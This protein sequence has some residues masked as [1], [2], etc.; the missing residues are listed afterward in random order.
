M[1]QSN[2]DYLVSEGKFEA[3]SVAYELK[4]SLK[5][6]PQPTWFVLMFPGYLTFDDLHQAIMCC[7][8]WMDCHLYDF[9]LPD[10]KATIKLL[11]EEDADFSDIIGLPQNNYFDSLS[12]TI[13]ELLNGCKK[14]KFEYSYDYGDGWE[15]VIELLSKNNNYTNKIPLVT[16]GKGIWPPEDC[17]GIGG[18]RNVLKLKRKQ[19]GEELTEQEQ[20]LAEWLEETDFDEFNIDDV[21]AMLKHCFGNED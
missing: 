12:T 7:T 3:L 20:D 19:D 11:G 18:F 10:K 21:N 13:S 4:I 6:A 1:T 8:N 16:A 17:G 14:C 15:C 2:Y 5:Y 9:Y